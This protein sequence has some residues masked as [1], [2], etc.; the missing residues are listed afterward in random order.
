MKKNKITKGEKILYFA[1]TYIY[2][3]E[4]MESRNVVDYLHLIVNADYGFTLQPALLIAAISYGDTD[5]IIDKKIKIVSKYLTKTLSW[6]VWNHWLTSQNQMEAKIYE[7]CKKIRNMSV[8][9]LSKYLNEH[10]LDDN[11]VD[12]SSP[13]L[14]QQNRVKIKVLLSLI[15]E[16]VARN[17]GTSDYMLNKKEI[18]VEHIWSNHYEQHLD[19]FDNESDFS[20]VRNSIGDLLV[21]PKSFNS[22]YGD[23]PY[24]D[25]VVQYFSQNILAQTL[26]SQKYSNNPGFVGFMQKSGLKFKSYSEFK[27]ASITERTDLYREILKYEFSEF[28]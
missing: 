8:D 6:R 9:E 25:K 28:L 3:M 5:E 15:T 27:R 7:L 21:L 24:E 1:K 4:L 20:T 22:S 23:A 12:G 17:S 19:E 13:H 16:V 2:I 11:T 14:N 26:N 10:P 18:E